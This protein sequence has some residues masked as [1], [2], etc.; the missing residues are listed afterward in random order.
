MQTVRSL[1]SCFP[2]IPQEVL[3]PIVSASDV[4]RG[5]RSRLASPYLPTITEE[6]SHG[7]LARALLRTVASPHRFPSVSQKQRLTSG[8]T[9]PLPEGWEASPTGQIPADLSPT[10]TR[11]PL[12]RCVQRA[13]SDQELIKQ[14]ISVLYGSLWYSVGSLHNSREWGEGRT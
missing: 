11:T 2:I 13:L 6:S 9:K 8:S 5:E 10:M 4:E 14:S 3:P 12:P 1:L 7:P